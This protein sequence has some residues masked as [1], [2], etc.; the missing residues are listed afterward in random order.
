MIIAILCMSCGKLIGDKW[1]YYE[2]ERKKLEQS[3]KDDPQPKNK[4][5][6]Y[7]DGVFTGPILDKLGLHRQCCRRHFLGNVELIETI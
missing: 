6:R 3:A 7:F 2:R 5:D 1:E 4:D